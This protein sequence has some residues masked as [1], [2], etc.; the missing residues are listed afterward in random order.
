MEKLWTGHEKKKYPIVLHLT[1]YLDAI[2][3]SLA[4]DILSPECQHFCQVISKSID[5]WQSYGPNTKKDLIFELS[6]LS[7]FLTLAL[8]TSF[9]RATHSVM[10]I[11][12]SVKSFKIKNHQV[13]DRT[14]YT[15]THT[16]GQGYPPFFEWR[17]HKKGNLNA[18]QYVD[19][20]LR[21]GVHPLF[22][23]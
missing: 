19:R 13:T 3:R 15:H 16:Y 12:I 14:K 8:Q 23:D 5:E 4:H 10:I 21:P 17:G 6:P 11:N 18:R 9:L 2:D 22:G 1:C 20:N 7:V